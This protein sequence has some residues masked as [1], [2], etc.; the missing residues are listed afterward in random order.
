M[1]KVCLWSMSSLETIDPTDTTMVI[2]LFSRV[3]ICV[4]ADHHL[5][6]SGEEGSGVRLPRRHLPVRPGLRGGRLH[7]GRCSS[8][9][10]LPLCQPQCEW[11]SHD[12]LVL[13]YILICV[14]WLQFL[15]LLL[16]KIV[17]KSWGRYCD[18]SW[19]TSALILKWPLITPFI[20]VKWKISAVKILIFSLK[21]L[22]NTFTLIVGQYTNSDM[23]IHTTT[24]LIRTGYEFSMYSFTLGV[25][26]DRTHTLG[27]PPPT[28]PGFQWWSHPEP[29]HIYPLHVTITPS[30]GKLCSKEIKTYI[31][32]R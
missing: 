4:G 10:R 20:I 23:N 27:A 30:A 14:A 5:R 9:K 17:S 26:W 12:H 19:N 18:I 28:P 2:S 6:R 29:G 22:C 7:C 24:T 16:L 1:G 25:R 32:I 21:L 13:P 31:L 8:G 15:P 11:P 3:Y